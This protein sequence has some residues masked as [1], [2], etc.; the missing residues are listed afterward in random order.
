MTTL[1]V[2]GRTYDHLSGYMKDTTTLQ[3]T[4]GTYDHLSGYMKDLRSPC[5]A[6]SYRSSEGLTVTLWVTGYGKDP[7]SHCG[8]QVTEGPTVTLQVT[9]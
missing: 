4:G 7:R 9:G 8:L 6:Y 1:Q 5:L 3:V 2:T